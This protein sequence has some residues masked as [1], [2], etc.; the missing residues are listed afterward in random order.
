MTVSAEIVLQTPDGVL[1]P[2]TASPER[3]AQC[4]HLHNAGAG[5]HDHPGA[6]ELNI[7]GRPSRLV[8]RNSPGIISPGRPQLVLRIIEAKDVEIGQGARKNTHA[9]VHG[10]HSFDAVKLTCASQD[11]AKP[12]E[13]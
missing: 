12:N 10:H 4:S 5:G 6:K 1:R 9:G 2:T 7:R 8:A 3:T 11:W 13:P